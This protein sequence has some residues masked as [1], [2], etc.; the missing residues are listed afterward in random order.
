[1]SIKTDISEI[2]R[3]IA[4]DKIKPL[5]AAN[6]VTEVMNKVV[7]QLESDSLAAHI[8]DM[9]S[10]QIKLATCHTLN[11]SHYGHNKQWFDHQIQHMGNLMVGAD[12]LLKKEKKENKKSKS[13]VVKAK[14]GAKVVR[15]S[16]KSRVN[17]PSKKVICGQK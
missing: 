4:S 1:M 7:L 15:K 17:K 11:Y 13:R 16:T 2:R 5:Q 9:L 12:K 8:Y 10:L 14:N 3:E 6:R